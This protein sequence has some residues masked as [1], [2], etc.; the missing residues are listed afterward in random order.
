MGDS[1]A[2]AAGHGS[3]AAKHVVRESMPHL[4]D[5]ELRRELE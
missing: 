4:A 1:L 2:A 3:E 5:T